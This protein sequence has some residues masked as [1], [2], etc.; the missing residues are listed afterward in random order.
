[1]RI[2]HNDFIRC[3]IVIFA[4]L[5]CLANKSVNRSTRKR[6]TSLEE[7]EDDDVMMYSM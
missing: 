6:E 1:M 7:E 5:K 4:L 2:I 3:W